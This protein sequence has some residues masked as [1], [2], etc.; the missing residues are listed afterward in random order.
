MRWAFCTLQP[1]ARPRLSNCCATAGPGLP[2]HRVSSSLWFSHLAS[3]SVTQTRATG[4][5]NLWLLLLSLSDNVINSL[6]LNGPIFL[7]RPCLPLDG[8]TIYK[9]MQ[10]VYR[11]KSPLLFPRHQACPFLSTPQSSPH[12]QVLTCPFRSMI[13]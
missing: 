4:S 13:I 2:G 6:N 1:S 5:R 8:N 3:L 7:Y 11:E 9:V 10:M 12:F